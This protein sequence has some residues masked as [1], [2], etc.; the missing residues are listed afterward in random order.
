MFAAIKEW[1]GEAGG[2]EG[3]VESFGTNKNRKIK[4]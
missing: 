1:D 4:Y 2:K 3:L